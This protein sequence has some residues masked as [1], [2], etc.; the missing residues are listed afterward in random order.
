METGVNSATVVYPNPQHW[1]D[2]YKA[3]LLETDKAKLPE[4][5]TRAEQV[6][7]TR[8]R[9]LFGGTIDH[10]E[11]TQALDDALYALRALQSCLRWNTR[12]A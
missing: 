7:I 6:I 1:R 10:V 2:F 8:A 11:E 3:A 4:R 5:V 9:Q 12:V